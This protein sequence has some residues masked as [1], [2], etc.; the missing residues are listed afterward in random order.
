MFV[1]NGNWLFFYFLVR[2]EVIDV[3]ENISPNDALGSKKAI[4]EIALQQF[5]DSSVDVICSTTGFTYLVS[6]TEHCEAQKDGV[7]CFVYKRP[8]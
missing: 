6:T 8:L 4:H 7:I 5:P 2:L 3:V 1:H